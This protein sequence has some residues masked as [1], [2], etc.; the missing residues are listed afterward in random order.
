MEATVSA[1]LRQANRAKFLLIPF[2]NRYCCIITLRH[3]LAQYGGVL[4]G[5]FLLKR[6]EPKPW[7]RIK[8]QNELKQRI[9]TKKQRNKTVGEKNTKQKGRKKTETNPYLHF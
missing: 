7:G 3:V 6:N 8:K 4:V 5:G 9:K 1:W 2:Y